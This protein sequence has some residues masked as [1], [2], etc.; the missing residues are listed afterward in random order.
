MIKYILL[1]ILISNSL[2]GQLK[3][4]EVLFLRWGNEKQ[5]AG[6]RTAPGG[7]YGPMSFIVQ[8]GAVKILDT[9]N[10][11]IKSFKDSQLINTISIP[12]INADDFCFDQNNN[13]YVLSENSVHKYQDKRL[14]K[15]FSPGNN[16][17]I[18][19][20][21]YSTGNKIVTIFN[22]SNSRDVLSNE[23]VTQGVL[24]FTGNTFE[25]IKENWNRIIIYKNGNHFAEITS[26]QSDLG[27][28]KFLGNTSN[29]EIYI[30]FEKIIQQV[31]L[32]VQK[33]I[34]LYNENGTIRNRTKVP[35]QSYTYIFKE[36]YVD[37]FGN[38]YHMLSTKEGIYIIKWITENKVNNIIDSEYPEKYNGTFHYNQIEEPDPILQKPAEKK[39]KSL[40]F[41][42]VSRDTSLFIGDTYTNHTWSA[43]ASNLT[44]GRITDPNGVEIETPPWVQVGSNIKIP[45][46]WGGF[47]TLAEFDNGLLN[48]KYAG[49]IATSGVSQYCVGVDCSGFVSKCWK[50]PY[51]F[52]TRMMDDWITVA[53]RSWTE[54][55][56]ADAIHKVGHVRMFVSTNPNGS[57]LTVESSGSD[58][59][60][61]YRSFN[62][63]QLTAYAPRYYIY[64]LGSP[65]TI[66]RSELNSITL[67]DSVTVNM[68]LSDTTD[69]AG[70]K[71]YES[72]DGI[73]WISVFGNQ[74]I[75]PQTNSV[76]LSK[77][78]NVE[79]YYKCKSVS[80]DTNAIESW[81]S[82]SYGYYFSSNPKQVLIVDGFDRI[83]GSYNLPYHDFITYS[84]NSI[85]HNEISYESVDNDAIIDGIV[86]LDSYD[87]VFWQL[88]DESTDEETFSTVEQSIV[89]SYLQQGGKM[90]I[91]GSEIAWD[92]DSQGNT[93]DQNFIHNILKTNYD[94]DDAESYLV[95]GETGT[96]FDGLVLHY[97]D[98]T[99]GVYPENYPDAYTPVN[100]SYSALRYDNS[101]IAA[102]AFEGIIPG[103]IS[104]AKIVM[105][106]FPFET[107]YTESERHDLINKILTFF[108]FN[109]AGLPE[110]DGI[111]PEIFDL[112]S[113]YP[114]PFNA[115][116]TI[117]FN[118]P[119]AGNVKI[120]LF[121]TLGQKIET[122]YDD[123]LKSGIHKIKFNGSHLASGIYFYKV[124]WNNQIKK[125]K[126]ILLK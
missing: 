43:A 107:I 59:R 96:I 92:L 50:L 119:A 87:A 89:T 63:S 39:T 15:I 79:N 120:V 34:Y 102:T 110:E 86:Q 88:G 124:N 35:Q 18:I 54:I 6:F 81:P 40:K 112:Y 16:Q 58:W 64:I 77:N 38:L 48:G 84:G 109:P 1:L 17:H 75:S 11:Q 33:Y 28:A 80:S 91:S 82:D 93:G 101:L 45:Y 25:V 7:H 85:A 19:T 126:F 44:N 51:Q 57:F 26:T 98:G 69:I 36:F 67:S 90:F 73:N 53:Y 68:Q 103:G 111:I 3:H 56:P 121:N 61:S 46:K 118:I 14:D 78:N 41:D 66:A 105:M 55:K 12:S 117:K 23:K 116:T 70:I 27:S 13:L 2:L 65:A 21:I 49:D 5:S 108:D 74:L 20:T 47:W 32:L 8:N 115:S 94:Q 123:N 97:D 31:P 83:D 22:E 76:I 52:S 29:G 100:G 9:Q 95:N 37:D 104:E 30:Y 72:S 125:S 113:N 42:P 106:G 99:H 114:N 62:L 24:D 122:I 10:N 60:V 71:L 4:E